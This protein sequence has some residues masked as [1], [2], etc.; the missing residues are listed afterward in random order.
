MAST[1]AAPYGLVPQKRED[2][3][4]YAGAVRHY[5]IQSGYATAIYNGMPV[6]Y[7]GGYLTACSAGN[8]GTTSSPDKLVGVFVGCSYTD[9]NTNQKVFKQYY[10][11]S[12]TAADITAYVVDDPKVIFKVQANSTAFDALAAIGTCYALTAATGGSTVTGNSSIALDTD[13]S[14]A[15]GN[16]LP[17]KVVGISGDPTNTNAGTGLYLDVLVVFH[18]S[19]HIHANNNG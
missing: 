5:R 9:P 1:T 13:G 7:T 8:M 14:P 11:A 17:C 12:T 16:T 18:P 10:P 19:F 2:G 3:M 4:P 15:A 6:A